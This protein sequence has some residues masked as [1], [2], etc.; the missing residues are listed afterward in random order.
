MHGCQ[1]RFEADPERE[2]LIR[3]S[4]AAQEPFRIEASPRDALVGDGVSIRVHGCRPGQVVTITARTPDG[5]N[6]MWQSYATFRADENGVVDVGTQQPLSGTYAGVDAGGLLWSM[7]PERG[8]PQP[9]VYEPGELEAQTIFLRVLDGESVLASAELVRRFAAPD[10]RRTAVRD[11]GLVGTFFARAGSAALPCIITLGGSEGG[12]KEE[13]ARLL[14][15][16]G[17]AAL[18]LAYF[19]A[20]TLP[21]K[22]VEIPLEYFETAL[23]WVSRRPEVDPHRIGIMGGSK[24]GEL[25]L[26]LG[27]KFPQVRAVIAGVPSGLVWQGLDMRA[28]EARI[29]MDVRR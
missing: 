26:L 13:W 22:L 10:L 18:A 7:V 28:R 17:F 8:A 5:R 15:S 25:A 11:H 23:Q 2:G 6:R 29:L 21:E 12:L 16:H 24:G 1:G 27:S 3:L 20:D 4:R 14:A 19:G 9:T